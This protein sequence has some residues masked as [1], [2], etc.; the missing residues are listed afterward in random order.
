MS[1]I[2]IFRQKAA[3]SS[4]I[5]ASLISLR[6]V[7]EVNS[8]GDAVKGAELGFRLGTGQEYTV[9]FSLG[10]NNLRSKVERFLDP[11]VGK[12][13]KE[14][15][16]VPDWST[17]DGT[18]APVPDENG[19]DLT[20]LVVSALIHDAKSGE[21]DPKN[22]TVHKMFMTP[23]GKTL[24]A[25]EYSCFIYVDESGQELAPAFGNR[26][27]ELKERQ[28]AAKQ[29]KKSIKA[30]LK[31]KEEAKAKAATQAS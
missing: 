18:T 15:Y 19:L 28:K 24:W 30:R 11:S 10:Q 12:F 25:Q 16:Q 26:T 2:Q 20:E 7:H 13:G 31:E 23:E 14:R 9:L 29:V 22:L 1:F 5:D 4:K 3:E 6:Y 27:Q 21:V 8:R 17:Y